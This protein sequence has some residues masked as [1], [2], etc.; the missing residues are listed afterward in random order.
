M[1]KHHR[2]TRSRIVGAK[3]TDDTLQVSSSSPWHQL[4]TSRLFC[5]VFTSRPVAGSMLV[6]TDVFTDS[7]KTWPSRAME[8]IGR[9]VVFMAC[10]LKAG[11]AEVTANKFRNLAWSH[12]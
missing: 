6:V 5:S 2:L 9:G 12:Q 7:W 8:W 1:P 11:A 4:I 10:S 3:R